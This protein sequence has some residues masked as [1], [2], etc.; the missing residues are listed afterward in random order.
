MRPL[1]ITDK[2]S[3]RRSPSAFMRPLNPAT[4]A[5]VQSHQLNVALS[6]ERQQLAKLA[7]RG[8]DRHYSVLVV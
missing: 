1:A 4:E 2:G 8:W 7:S 5:A 3:L 6:S